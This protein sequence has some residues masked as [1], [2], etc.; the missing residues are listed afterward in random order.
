MYGYDDDLVI[1]QILDHAFFQ[2]SVTVI[3]MR[4]LY[5]P[6]VKVKEVYE[7]NNN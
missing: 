4:N 2:G 6:S 3:I 5:V 1:T 7:F